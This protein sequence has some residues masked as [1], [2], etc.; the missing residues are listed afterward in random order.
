MNTALRLTFHYRQLKGLMNQRKDNPQCIKTNG[1]IYALFEE[2]EPFALE[3]IDS[4]NESLRTG[5]ALS[6][7]FDKNFL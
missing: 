5:K 4:F 3:L 1:E 2:A 6:K 7:A